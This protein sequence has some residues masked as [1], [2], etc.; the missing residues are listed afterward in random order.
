MTEYRAAFNALHGNQPE[1]WAAATYYASLQVLE[2]AIEGADSTDR[3]AV[4]EY[5]KANSFDTALGTI[6]F[7]KH[8]ESKHYWTVGQWHDGQF[9]AVARRRCPGCGRAGRQGRLELK[10]FGPA[11]SGRSGS[12]RELVV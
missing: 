3:E 11:G 4:T 10:T 5:I 1:Y 12:S 9:N 6:S 7:D 2:Q 8:N